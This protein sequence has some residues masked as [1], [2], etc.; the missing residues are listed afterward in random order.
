MKSIM[1]AHAHAAIHAE[2]HIK[3]CSDWHRVGLSRG[4]LQDLPSWC[5][6]DQRFELP[7]EQFELRWCRG[8][9]LA[10]VGVHDGQPGCGFTCM[11]WCAVIFR[12]VWGRVSHP[13]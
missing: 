4:D 8:G 2:P 6:G 9:V 1:H 3:G 10:E 12:D 11:A 13:S 7:V 5:A